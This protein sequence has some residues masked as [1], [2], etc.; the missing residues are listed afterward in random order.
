MRHFVSNTFFHNGVQKAIAE[1]KFK[2]QTMDLTVWLQMHIIYSFPVTLKIQIVQFTI[3]FIA[4][5]V[6]LVVL[7]RRKE[8]KCW[9]MKVFLSRKKI[10]INDTIATSMF[11]LQKVGFREPQLKQ[12][13]DMGPVMG[14]RYQ[15]TQVPA[16]KPLL[17]SNTEN[18]IL[19][20]FIHRQC[21]NSKSFNQK[22]Y[23]KRQHNSWGLQKVG[24]IEDP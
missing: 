8:E 14:A 12:V 21:Q 5:V 6:T 10:W 19:T 22:L 17:K 15:I 18:I 13:W 4:S 1:T 11:T 7:K 3:L 23:W 2:I 24:I 9:K 20:S 16:I